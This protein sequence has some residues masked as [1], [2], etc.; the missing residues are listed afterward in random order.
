MAIQS[1]LTLVVLDALEAAGLGLR[2]DSCIFAGDKKRN[3]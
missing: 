2:Y 3:K 1:L